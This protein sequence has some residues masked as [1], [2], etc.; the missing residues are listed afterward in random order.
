MSFDC[1]LLYHM[2]SVEAGVRDPL[3]S[4][5]GKDALSVSLVWIAQSWFTDG[6]NAVSIAD[7]CNVENVADIISSGPSSVIHEFSRLSTTTI[8]QSSAGG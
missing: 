5:A 3:L 7:A 4:F 8:P 2:Q 1:V 6:I